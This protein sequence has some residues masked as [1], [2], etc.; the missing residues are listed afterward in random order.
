MPTKARKVTPTSEWKKGFDPLLELPSGKIVRV[1]PVVNMRT[2]LSAGIIP[3]SLM[4]IVQGSLDK[5]VEPDIS[6]FWG[7][8]QK[9]NQMMEMV[10]NI[11]VFMT[12]EPEIHQL[13]KTNEDRDPA[14]LYVDEIADTDKMYIFQWA[15]GGTRDLEQFHK[16]S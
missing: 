7:D 1:R 5:G 14:L 3:N 16:E 9:I 6:S 8:S 15:I 11:V 4:G 13:P 2:F 12:E 10:D